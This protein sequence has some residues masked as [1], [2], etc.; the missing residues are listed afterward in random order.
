VCVCACVRVS[1][2][3]SVCL[4]MRISPEPHAR[5]LPFLCM[6]P[7]AVARSSSDRVTKSQGEGAV[8][9]VFFPIDNSLYSIAFWTH[10]KTAELIKIPYGMMSGLGPRNSVLRYVR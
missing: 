8:L 3:L 5:S 9:E 7:M 6:L 1:V 2:C 4:S 10:I